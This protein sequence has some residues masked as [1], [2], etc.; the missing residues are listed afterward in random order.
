MLSGPER[1]LR[2]T[3][4]WSVTAGLL[5]LAGDA[6]AQDWR[7]SLSRSGPL[8]QG[9]K[10]AE[11]DR[12]LQGTPLQRFQ[13]VLRIAPDLIGSAVTPCK[14]LAATLE[15]RTDKGSVGHSHQLI[16][17]AATKSEGSYVMFE[18][19]LQC[20]VDQPRSSTQ[21]AKRQTGQS[22]AHSFGID[23]RNQESHYFAQGRDYYS[24]NT[25]NHW[26]SQGSALVRPWRLVHTE[27]PLQRRVFDAI[28]LEIDT[29]R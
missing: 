17:T 20:V 6:C 24:D 29:K 9:S 3:W 18:L 7:C 1:Q 14:I 2:T 13:Q 5:L 27:Q 25:S 10:A 4:V 15:P 8:C 11:K 26:D 12:Q 21:S 16:G 28:C 19:T 22:A 23:C